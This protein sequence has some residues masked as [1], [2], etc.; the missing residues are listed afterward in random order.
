M[1]KMTPGPTKLTDDDLHLF[2][3]GSHFQLYDKLGSHAVEHNGEKGVYFAVWAPNA[4]SVYLMGD[5]NYWSKSECPLLPKGNSGIW[6]LFVPGI[7]PGVCYKYHIRS[8]WNNFEVDNSMG[9]PRGKSFLFL[10][11]WNNA[12]VDERQRHRE[13]WRVME[14]A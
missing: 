9:A 2:N 7:H 4:E 10:E 13:A 11:N 1:G 3:E 6:E 12:R 8:K 14:I 5:F